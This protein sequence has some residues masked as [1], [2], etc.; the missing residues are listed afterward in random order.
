MMMYHSW[1]SQNAW[2]RQILA[3]NY[4]YMNRQQAEAMG[5]KDLSWIWLESKTGRI[6]VQVKL[7]EGVEKSTVWTWNAFGKQRGTWGLD[8]DA[9]E[10]NQ[11]FL[12]N[13]LINEHLPCG[14]TGRPITNSDPITGQA[15]WYDLQ[16][17]IYPAKAGEV[18]I[19]PNFETIKPLPGSVRAK[20]KLRYQTHKAVGVSRSLKDILMRGD[21]RRDK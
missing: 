3:Q 15:A 5:I 4:M 18:G 16:V 9:N 8:A 20:D 21:T 10:S 7:M 6:R 17:K 14:D 2:L 12:L 11:G 13:H 19:W 1:D